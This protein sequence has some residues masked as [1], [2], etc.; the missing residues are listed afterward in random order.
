MIIDVKAQCGQEMDLDCVTVYCVRE[1]GHTG[2]CEF[3]VTMPQLRKLKMQAQRA[4][5]EPAK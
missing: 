4:R 3:I 1:R 2:P 5:K